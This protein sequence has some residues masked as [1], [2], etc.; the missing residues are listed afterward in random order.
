MLTNLLSFIFKIRD[1]D[2][3]LFNFILYFF[4]KKIA[5]EHMMITKPLK[6]SPRTSAQ[7]YVE[8]VPACEI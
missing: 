6:F 5:Q 4:A 3:V 2:R 7:E 8:D 1:T